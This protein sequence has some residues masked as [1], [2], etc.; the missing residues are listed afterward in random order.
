MSTAKGNQPFD[1]LIRQARIKSSWPSG[2]TFRSTLKDELGKSYIIPPFSVSS[3]FP[4]LFPH[5][6]AHG[7]CYPVAIF[8]KVL[9]T[10]E[11]N[12]VDISES[13]IPGTNTYRIEENGQSLSDWLFAVYVHTPT[14][15][16]FDAIQARVDKERKWVD[17]LTSFTMYSLP[18]VNWDTL[19]PRNLG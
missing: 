12:F 9:Q 10:T 2:P 15:A 1:V 6:P 8:L 14:I 4:L 18:A 16:Y 11:D 17:T 7:Y 19:E 13:A 5:V 3:G